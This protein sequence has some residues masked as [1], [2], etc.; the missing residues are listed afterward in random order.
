[1]RQD[2]GGAR[3]Y[4]GGEVAGNAQRTVAIL[5]RRGHLHEDGVKG[6]AFAQPAPGGGIGHRQVVDA[7][8]QPRAAQI[9]AEEDR[10]LACLC[11]QAG[12]VEGI[13]RGDVHAGEAQPAAA[14]ATA[15][16]PVFEQQGMAG[17]AGREDFGSLR[18]VIE[19]S[20]DIQNSGHGA[21]CSVRETDHMICPDKVGYAPFTRL[22]FPPPKPAVAGLHRDLIAR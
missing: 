7:A 20:V 8:I 22:P 11:V 17:T 21:D 12:K 3:P 15:A 4:R 2:A 14:L 5:V 10:A 19:E 13:D 6:H 18:E 9:A 16:Q 1:M